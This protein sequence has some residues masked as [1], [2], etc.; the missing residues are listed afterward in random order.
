VLKNNEREMLKEER[1][2]ENSFPAQALP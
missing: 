1:I 2:V